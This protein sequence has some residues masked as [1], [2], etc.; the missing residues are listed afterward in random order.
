MDRVRFA[1]I[2]GQFQAEPALSPA[3]IGATQNASAPQASGQQLST[4]SQAEPRR[5]EPNTGTRRIS[6][7]A[8]K[9]P[10]FD[11]GRLMPSPRYYLGA[12]A[13]LLLVCMLGWKFILVIRARSNPDV[14]SSPVGGVASPAGSAIGRETSALAAAVPAET[15]DLSVEQLVKG[16]QDQDAAG[17]RR[18]AAAL[19]AKGTEVK[20]ALPALRQALKDPDAEVQMWS[21]L[22]LVNNQSYDPATIPILLRLL[23][24][25][26]PTLRQVACLSLGVIPYQP[27]DKDTVASA[28]AQ[29]AGTDADA[30]VRKAALASLNLIAPELVRA[31]EAK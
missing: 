24:D 30:T 18:A 23:H 21:A 27:A 20:E 4:P 7:L 29:T 22:T 5:N 26:N 28:L 2:N 19:H 8:R 14:L 1:E 31:P 3:A 9:Q 12:V 13:A 16:L 11:A 6:R 10:G 25:D 15:A 17:R